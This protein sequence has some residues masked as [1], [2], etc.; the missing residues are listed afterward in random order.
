M[1]SIHILGISLAFLGC[2]S[3]AV[4]DAAPES[5][6]GITLQGGKA[7][8][9]DRLND[10]ERFG[11]F[12][13]SD[14]EY[15]LAALPMEGV[16]KKEPWPATY[17]PTFQDSTNVRWDGVDTLSP[18]EKYDLVFNGW[19]PPPGFM[20]LRPFKSG[21]GQSDYDP[22]YY[23][24]IGPA[25]RWM[26]ENRGHWAAHDGIDS[27]S[28]GTVDECGDR[29]GIEGWWGL[30]HA[31]TPAAL[32]ED[33]PTNTIEYEGVT[34]YPSD[35]KALMITVYDSSKAVVIGGRCKTRKVE[36]DT[37]GRILDAN[38][39][40][41]NAGTFH[42]IAANF[43]GRFQ[44]GFAE[45]RTYDGEVWNQPVYAYNVDTLKEVE[46]QKAIEL[47]QLDGSGGEK[48]AFNEDAK[49][50]AEVVTTVQ[51]VVESHPSREAMLPN[52]QGYLRTDTYHYLLEMDG[53]GKIIGGEWLNADA[54]GPRGGISGQ[55]DF[56]WYPTGPRANP[57]PNGV[58]GRIDPRKNPHVSYSKVS[59]LFELSQQGSN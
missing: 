42:V 9:W 55:P 51:Y 48:Y 39:R 45:D 43:L 19:V 28:D 27:D 37:N 44:T 35:L 5:V 1:K 7:D 56:L 41:T 32:I 26:S 50:W 16:S 58:H 33:E 15:T 38:C 21:C 17:W 57:L 22:E 2:S 18:M 54:E 25:A 13:E 12:L 59:R 10:P 14:L 30:C 8:Q 49:R 52:F 29:D 53:D 3:P 36:R 31:W 11:R 6:S 34:F 20:E 40:D 47:T 4:E 23:D 46:E 24:A